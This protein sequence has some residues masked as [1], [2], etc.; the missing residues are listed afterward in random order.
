MYAM[1]SISIKQLRLATTLIVEL[2]ESLPLRVSNSTSPSLII[3][4]HLLQ[5]ESITKEIKVQQRYE[6]IL[7]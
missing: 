7:V 5:Q 2:S 4:F 6:M 1:I 3:T